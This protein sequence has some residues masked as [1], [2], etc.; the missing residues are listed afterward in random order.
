M[1]FKIVA[2]ILLLIIV[3]VGI[4]LVV[5]NLFKN[6]EI[7]GIKKF[8]Y[9]S[10]G[11]MAYNGNSKYEI[12]CDNECIAN[13]KM[14]YEIEKK[15]I[16]INPDV[17]DKLLNIFNKYK[18]YNWNGF[19]KT[20]KNVL[21]GS[22]FSISIIDDN[23][24]S[25]DAHGYMK[26]PRN[27]REVIDNIKNILDPIYL[28]VNNIHLFDL[29]YYE[30]FDISNV[31]KVVVDKITEAG[32]DTEEIIDKSKIFDIYNKWKNVRIL[33][34]CNKACDDNTIIYKFIVEDNKEYK[35][36]K[37]CDWLI[38]DHMRYYFELEKH[39]NS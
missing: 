12:I 26:Y 37:E 34:K 20:D 13:I 27:Y 39:T 14:P 33:D 29:D 5:F 25:I 10:S 19:D 1:K 32:I 18:V 21:D 9:T 31:K 2:F 22:S 17:V 11:G 38:I 7:T 36:E 28:G 6:K 23:D 24:Y 4:I 30:G 15:N 3:A 8:S 16:T 35:I